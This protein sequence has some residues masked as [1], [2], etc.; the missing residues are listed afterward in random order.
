V[1]ND[2]ALLKETFPFGDAPYAVAIENGR[3]K[4]SLAH[5]DDQQPATELRRADFIR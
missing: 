5:F 4:L 1:S 3:Q 2:L